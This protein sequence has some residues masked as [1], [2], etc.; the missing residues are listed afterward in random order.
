M[1]ETIEEDEIR[2]IWG[3]PT[4]R[5]KHEAPKMGKSTFECAECGSKFKVDRKHGVIEVQGFTD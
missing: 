5:A 1:P 4:C 2:R 3:C